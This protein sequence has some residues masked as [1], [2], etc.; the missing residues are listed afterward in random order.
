ML[1]QGE[2]GVLAVER[3]GCL[4]VL[5]MGGCGGGGGREV[6]FTGI[7][8]GESTVLDCHPCLNEMTDV[9]QSWSIWRVVQTWARHSDCTA[10]VP[11]HV[12][13]PCRCSTGATPA[14]S[15]L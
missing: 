5:M 9:S 10:S 15:S 14:G 3:D 7:Q 13:I 8:A 2:Q 6:S 1:Q 12:P 4:A 11:L